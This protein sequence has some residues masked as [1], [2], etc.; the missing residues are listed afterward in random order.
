M[1]TRSLLLLCSLWLAA[2]PAS[3]AQIIG[4][5]SWSGADSTRLVLELDGPSEYRLS[6][7]STPGQLIITLPHATTTI[8]APRWPAQVG[9]VQ[10]S[11]LDVSERLPRLLIDL[12]REVDAKVFLLGP[13]GSYGHR[14][15]VDLQPREGKRVKGVKAPQAVQVIEPRPEPE[16]RAEPRQEPRVEPRKDSK[17]SGL[18]SLFSSAGKG[19][20]IV[21][22]VDPGHGGEDPG[23][24]GPNGTREKM[25]TLAIGH[26]VVDWLNQQDGVTANLTRDSDFFIPLQK[27][28]QIGRYDHKADIFV[29]VHADSAPS[30]L[31]RGASVFALS[32]KGVNSATSRF[33]QQ[34]A[35]QENKS[36][37]IGGVAAEGDD[38]GGM[39]A[40][41][42]VEGTLKHSLEMGRLILRRLEPTVGRLHNRTVEQA[43]FAVLKEPGMVSLLVETGFISNPEEEQQLASPEYQQEVARSIGEGIISFCQQYP[44]PGTWFARD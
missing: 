28:R 4:A 25:V 18:A 41:L 15:V 40:N 17:P 35:E 13:S 30:R 37:L 29:S 16:V 36:D 42:L 31:A 34:L 8:E 43:G 11:R 10:A 32:I 39:L 21:I 26:A 5:R 3:A 9:F 1:K 44:V 27:R 7:D 22:T 6:E 24:I 2:L 23:A 12:N 33:A 19:R 38:I 20:R 14:L